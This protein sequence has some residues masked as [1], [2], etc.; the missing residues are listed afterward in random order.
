MRASG[1]TRKPLSPAMAHLLHQHQQA[2]FHSRLTPCEKLSVLHLL[3][4]NERLHQ[5]PLLPPQK[6]R[7]SLFLD[8]RM[9]VCRAQVWVVGAIMMI[10]RILRDALGVRRLSLPLFRLFH[11]YQ[12]AHR[13]RQSPKEKDP[14]GSLG[15]SKVLH[16]PPRLQQP[17]LLLPNHRHQ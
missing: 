4:P 16:H 2:S 13:V 17:L 1:S 5:P 9:G 10:W 6:E 8:L 3:P 14:R 12:R 15:N 7:D 11:R